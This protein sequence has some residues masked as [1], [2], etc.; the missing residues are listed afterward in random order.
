MKRHLE[1]LA[2]KSKLYLKG[3]VSHVDLWPLRSRQV[4]PDGVKVVDI[5]QPI[6]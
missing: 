4:S 2:Q 5:Q 3:G 6:H 1:S